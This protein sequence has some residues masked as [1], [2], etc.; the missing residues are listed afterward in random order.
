LSV[1]HQLSRSCP[2]SIRLAALA[3]AL[4]AAI[5]GGYVPTPAYA[6]T[7][8]A[9]V[10]DV[11]VSSFSRTFQAD[12]SGAAQ[13]RS[14]ASTTGLEP[15]HLIG[16]SWEGAADDGAVRVRVHTAAGWQAWQDLERERAETPDNG[17]EAH[18]GTNPPSL[19][20]WVGDADGF[21]LDAPPGIH[22]VVVHLVRETKRRTV[23]PS[24][25]S[26]AGAVTGSA[27][28]NPGVYSRADWGAR[29][30]AKAPQYASALR[31]AI[32]HHT[33]NSNDYGPDDVPSLLRGI[34]A[35]HMD[36]N[37]WGDIGYNFLVDRFGRIWE[38]R[39]GGI[40]RPVIGAHSG[41]FNT[42]STGVAIIGDF[43]TAGPTN[44]S[45]EATARVVGWKL[46][47]AGVDPMGHL[48]A[49]S[50]SDDNTAHPTGST[51]YIPRV[52]GHRDTWATSCPGQ[53][54][55]DLLPAIS[56]RAAQLYPYI[57]GSF[58]Q[59][60][61]SPDGLRVRGWSLA[62]ST[63]NPILVNAIMD[64]GPN[65][66]VP[67]NLP[68]PDIAAAFPDFGD[69]HGYSFTLGAGPGAHTVCL[70]GVNDGDGPNYLL[71]CRSIFLFA[72]PGGNLDLVARAPGG[73]RVAGWALDPNTA[74]ATAVDV[75]VN[76]VGTRTIAN[77]DRP[78][79]GAMAPDYGPAHGY[80]ITVPA[81]SGWYQ[82][83]AYAINLG[84]GTTNPQLGCRTVVVSDQPMGSLD[85]ASRDGAFGWVIDPNSKGPIDV[86]LYLNGSFL[87]AVTANAPRGDVGEAFPD[88]G[89]AH[90]YTLG[91]SPALAAGG[92]LC[93]YAINVGPGTSNPQL[94]CR[95][96]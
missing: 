90:G 2:R 32:V 20:V 14:G 79:V 49:T 9:H 76:G 41:G 16:A 94:G 91:F 28:G 74:G 73:I 38:G 1:S 43:R 63:A 27:G 84:A 66:V 31:N 48:T 85:G 93:A 15:F 25:A 45:L 7:A 81:A 30:A 19:P 83:C 6:E 5:V 54:L 47:N 61:Q 39:S 55:Y 12:A 46:A 59:I 89:S 77:T 53:V 72:N 87:T 18:P 26:P 11:A 4:I 58:D 29:D 71:G 65:N 13:P 56:A 21:E 40:D 37:G 36:A 70:E 51:V 96:V 95:T 78:D 69:P 34:Q 52:S 67:A 60:S 82:V 22:D 88:Y 62:R 80:D 50:L 23:A 35:Y 92:T 17:P 44:E 10:D 57:L 68:R 8:V 24:S 75:Y 3:V 33:V 64:G 86:H 42:G